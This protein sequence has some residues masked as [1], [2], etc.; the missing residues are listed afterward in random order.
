MA[1]ATFGRMPSKFDPTQ[2]PFSCGEAFKEWAEEL[3]D[4]MQASAICHVCLFIVRTMNAKRNWL[5]CMNLKLT[6][7]LNDTDSER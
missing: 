5:P 1:M 7:L 2:H 4:Y 6:K 3:D